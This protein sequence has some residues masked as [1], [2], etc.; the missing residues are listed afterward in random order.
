MLRK[1]SSKIYFS[2]K[3]AIKIRTLPFSEWVQINIKTKSGKGICF[4]LFT[5][6]SIVGFAV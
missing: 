3:Y 6:C 4:A 2:H 5:S 1:T